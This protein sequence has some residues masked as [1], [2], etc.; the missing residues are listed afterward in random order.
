M[1]LYDQL[2][3]PYKV[4]SEDSN[5]PWGGFVKISETDTTNFI[6]HFFKERATE[7]TASRLNVSPKILFVQP[8]KRLSWQ[9]HHRRSELWKVVQGPIGIVRSHDD[10]EWPIEV[11]ESGTL[12]EFKAGERHRLVGLNHLGIVAELWRHLDPKNPSDEDDIVR[13]QDDYGR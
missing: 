1:E 5:R 9:Y 4:E 2:N 7:I 3:L 13:L 8:T 12:I 6:F 10:T 11:V